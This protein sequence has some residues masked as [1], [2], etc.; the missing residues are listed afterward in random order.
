MKPLFARWLVLESLDDPLRHTQARLLQRFA[1]VM[2]AAALLSLPVSLVAQSAIE[3]LVGASTAL[4]LIVLLGSAM[5]LLRRDRLLFAGLLIIVSTAASAG[6]NMSTTGIEGSRAIFVLLIIPIVLGGLLGDRRLLLA[7]LAICTLV[8]AGIIVGEIAAP[9]LVGYQP[10]TYDPL[11]TFVTFVLCAGILTLMVG[12]F[13]SAL[14]RALHAALGRERELDSLR[15][16]LEQQ[17]AERTAQLTRALDEMRAQSDA[18]AALL[19][20]LEQQ[21]EAIREL[22]V[23]V[24][25]LQR[26]M[27]AMPL[28]GALDSARLRDLQERALEAIQRTSAGRLLLDITGVPIVDTQVAHGLIGVVQAARLLGTEVLLVGIRP[29]VAQTI[30]GLGLDLRGVQ[31]YSDIETALA[32][33]EQRAGRTPAERRANTRNPLL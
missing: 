27:L 21:R 20:T 8:P 31:T 18:Q 19:D 9:S 33:N 2:L 32:T 11:L 25:P 17:V 28:I 7:A 6:L 15:A 24:L 12:Y 16:S 29:E 13:G 14:Q 1:L 26:G 23:P 22:S 30:I 5:L 4:A 10:D 3:R